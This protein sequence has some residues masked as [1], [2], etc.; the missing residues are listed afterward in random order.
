MATLTE[1]GKPGE[2]LQIKTSGSQVRKQISNQGLNNAYLTFY[3]TC[4]DLK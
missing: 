1:G 2:Y 4:L 3:F